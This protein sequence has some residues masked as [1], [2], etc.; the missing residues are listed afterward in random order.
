MAFVQIGI[1]ETTASSQLKG[2]FFK[3]RI[4]KDPGESENS[5]EGEGLKFYVTQVNNAPS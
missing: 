5:E 1:I 3:N 4:L 2:F